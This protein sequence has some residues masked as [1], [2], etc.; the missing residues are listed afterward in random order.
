M[1]QMVGVEHAEGCTAAGKQ[2]QLGTS[3]TQSTADGVT[4]TRLQAS[5]SS[6]SLVVQVVGTVSPR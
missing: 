1:P 2:L 4:V 3:S 6:C 5:C